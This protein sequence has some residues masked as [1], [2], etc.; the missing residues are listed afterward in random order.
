[1]N[2]SN[3]SNLKLLWSAT[4]PSIA[5]TPV[6][7]NGIV[8]ATGGTF[9][10]LPGQ[11]IGSIYA[12]NESNGN[13]IWTDGGNSQTGLEFSDIAGVALDRGNVFA[14]TT[15]NLLVSLNARSGALNW[16]V[17]IDQAIVD[18]P[19]AQY[20][21][22]QGTI[23]VWN[24]ELITGNTLGNTEARGFIR[25]FSETNG[26]LLWTFYTVPPSPI[27]NSSG[28]QGFYQ[29][30]WGACTF[31]GGGDSWNV[32]AL[33]S[34]TGIIYFGTGDPSPSFNASERAPNSSDANLYTDC[35]IALNA[36]SGNMI[37]YY[38]E[39]PSD[40]HDW[41]AGMPV[42][43]FNTTINGGPEREVVG[44]GSKSGYYYELDAKTGSLIHAIS[45]GI[46]QNDGA[47][48]TTSG[49]I[50]L[51]GSFG[52]INTDPSFDPFTNMIYA[53]VF[54]WATNYTASD[55]AL[56]GEAGV[57]Y[58]LGA[59]NSTLYAINATSGTIVWSQNLRGLAG[60]VSSTND[61]VF[62]SD[63]SGVYYAFDAL[64][65]NLLWNYSSGRSNPYGLANWGPPSVTGGIVFETSY[66]K[67]G[68]GIM[69]FTIFGNSSTSSSGALFPSLILLLLPSMSLSTECAFFVAIVS[70]DR[71]RRSHLIP[72]KE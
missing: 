12:L 58:M 34:H 44:S 48:P 26:A 18:N 10:S 4:I 46:H 32:P 31:C 2:S 70:I 25:A 19:G 5:G 38:Q 65:G 52:G 72:K 69:A 49:V 71:I 56:N 1:M 53:T 36:T 14:G 40:T 7:S 54:N 30:S 42:Q 9:G 66:V 62:T 64:N 16:E 61:I 50:V 39:T 8:Y 35:V 47:V 41:D 60:G 37:W 27:N 57:D 6:I 24:G 20:I 59:P 23:L 51:P 15:N 63:S 55:V 17:N 28:D 11:L 21:G 22:P 43:L 29:N 13:L 68:G 33:D 3:V 45:L 67:N